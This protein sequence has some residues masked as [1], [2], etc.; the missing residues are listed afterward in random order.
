MGCQVS[1]KGNPV[2]LDMDYEYN[3]YIYVYIVKAGIF[4]HNLSPYLAFNLVCILPVNR[5]RLV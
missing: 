4:S 3:I 1:P 2:G 5:R